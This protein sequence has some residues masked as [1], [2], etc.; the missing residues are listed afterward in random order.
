VEDNGT[1]NPAG[2]DARLW[3]LAAAAARV[4]VHHYEALGNKP[5]ADFYRARLKEL[6]RGPEE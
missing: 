1:A 3:F 5:S 2:Q 4:A 6:G